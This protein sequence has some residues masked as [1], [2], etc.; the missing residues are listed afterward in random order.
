MNPV[1]RANKLDSVYFVPS[2]IASM[3]RSNDPSAMN[4]I[5]ERAITTYF[6]VKHDGGNTIT[7]SE[8]NTVVPGKRRFYVLSKL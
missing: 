4:Q 5:S 1:V 7:R 2:P 8:V 6:S 3:W